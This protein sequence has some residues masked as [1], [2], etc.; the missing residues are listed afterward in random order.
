MSPLLLSKP[1]CILKFEMVEK[2]MSALTAKAV[3]W[4]ETGLVPDA[5]IRAGIRRLLEAR[6]KDIHSGDI[7]FAAHATNE[8][9]RMMD[10]SPIAL[11]PERAN[12]QHY[13][14]PAEFF[15]E[16]MGDWLKYSCC[17]WPKNVTTL[18]EAEAA[19]LD[20]T[21]QRA[22]IEDGM[23]VLDLGCGWGSLSLWIAEHFPNTRVMSVSNSQVQRAHIMKQADARSL[24]NIEVVTRDM[25]DFSTKRTFDRVLSIEMFEHMRNY[26]ELFGR[27]SRWLRPDGRF[28]MHIFCHRTTPYV[29][30][31]KGPGDWMSR[32]FFTGGIMP[33]SSLPLRFA[34]N[35]QI[36]SQWAWN[37]QHYTKTCNAWLENM[38]SRRDS[39]M[40]ILVACYG[41]DA[42]D[43]F[44]QRW[45]IFFMACAELFDYDEGNEWFVSHYLF[46]QAGP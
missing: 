3:G 8:F 15:A 22:G 41:E 14:V 35:L 42:A 2:P 46:R 39:I 32:H 33:S 6:R 9:V 13:A 10:A 36:E 1:I 5:V 38:D 44:W 4:T 17:Y 37:G 18:S 24:K 12:E 45:R 21:V 19:A 23:T 29:Y 25:N 31:D 28:F 40:P 34:D 20:K 7:S 30:E 26:R 43:V 11:V 16:V 27:I